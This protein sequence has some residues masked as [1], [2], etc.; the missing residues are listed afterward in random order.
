MRQRSMQPV[1]HTLAVDVDQPVVRR[2]I[3][4]SKRPPIRLPALVIMTSRRSPWFERIRLPAAIFRLCR[5][6]EVPGVRCGAGLSDLAGERRQAGVVDVVG[7]D[8]VT[9]GRKGQSAV[10]RPMPAAAPVM[11]TLRGIAQ[12]FSS[13]APVPGVSVAHRVLAGMAKG[14]LSRTTRRC[15]SMPFSGSTDAAGE[16]TT[17]T[18]DNASM[19]REP[20]TW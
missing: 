4:S 13:T 1:D 14:P 11:N 16:P 6:L 18:G 15:L 8:D 2:P 7:A 3:Y 10:G 17:V 5:S 9:L 12:P 19:P 20:R